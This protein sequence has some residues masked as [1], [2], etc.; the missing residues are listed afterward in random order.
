MSLEIDKTRDADDL[1]RPEGNDLQSNY[2]LHDVGQQRV[3]ERMESYGLDVVEWGIDMRDAGDDKLVFDD[4]MDLRIYDEGELAALVEVKTKS[5]AQYMG[6]FNR[7]HYKHY[8]EHAQDHDVP[9]FVVMYQI[10]DDMIQDVFV[11]PIGTGDLFDET[12][13][14]DFRFP[15]GNEGVCVRHDYRLSWGAFEGAVL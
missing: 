5:N 6:Q 3:K 13:P 12:I 9:A 10:T 15:D 2:D 8:Y 4:A 11:T 7:R 1:D 14:H